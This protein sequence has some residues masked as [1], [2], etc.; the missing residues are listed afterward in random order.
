MHYLYRHFDKNGTLLYVGVT[1]NPE[2]RL[3]GHKSTAHWYGEIAM[4]EM[5]KIGVKADALAK[6]RS[7][8]LAEKPKHNKHKTIVEPQRASQD[9]LLEPWRKRAKLI[10]EMLDRGNSQSDIAR[11]FGVSRQAISVIV[12]REKKRQ[13]I[14]QMVARSK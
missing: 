14:N 3:T 1:A 6:E 10:M 8:I 2:M 5:E 7:I 12:N 9:E 4:I 13:A 11:R